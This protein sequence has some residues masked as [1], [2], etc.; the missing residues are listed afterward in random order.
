M[1]KFQVSAGGAA[2]CGIYCDKGM[3]KAA[4]QLSLYL[5]QITGAEF[6]Q[7]EERKGKRFEILQDETAK[8]FTYEIVEDV[9]VIK[10]PTHIKAGWGVFHML[11]SLAD[12]VF[13][14]STYEQIP[15]D[16]DLTLETDFYEHKPAFEFSKTSY[17]DH[18]DPLYAMK[19]G[20]DYMGYSE[21]DRDRLWG[22][23]A[24]HTIGRLVGY[25]KFKEHPE[26]FCMRDGKRLEPE[27]WMTIGGGMEIGNMQPC[28]SN[29][30]VFEI[31]CENLKKQMDAKPEAL[32]WSVSQDDNFNYC[33]CPECAKVDEE[34]GSHLGTYL[35]FVNKVAERFPD[36]IIST[37]AYQFT[38][39]PCKITK[40]AKNVN[41]V[42]CN[43]EAYRNKPI[44]TDPLN[45]DAKNELI[46]WRE[47]ADD[48]FYWDYCIQFTHLVSPF[49]NFRTLAENMKFFAEGGIRIMFSQTNR[50]WLGE[51]AELRGYY[52][53]KL[54]ENPWQDPQKIIE[55]FC[56]AYYGEASEYILEYIQIMHDALDA[57]PRMQMSIFGSPCDAV[58]SYLR[59]ELFEKYMNL[60]DEA[61]KAVA[62]DAELLNHVRVA[63]MPLYYAGVEIGYGDKYDQF[64]MLANFSKIAKENNVDMVWEVGRET[65]NQ[66]IANSMARLGSW[67]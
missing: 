7:L 42:L 29:P 21:E 35:R 5:T 11:D 47:I 55:R 39:K 32:Y 64:E 46:A 26:Y 45:V 48:I 37:L 2:L 3:E 31:V 22:N 44:V 53:A 1:S 36:K 33:Q 30:D 4:E 14:T 50:E 28:L 9:F 59:R 18:L 8:F 34:E 58:S 15:N 10:A 27:E 65:T 20:S 66:F 60:F 23:G 43:I 38:R 67:E 16:P 24:C 63:R 62:N 61:E 57:A 51:F 52:L 41:I 13:C 56:D 6:V 25:E 40:P 49:P 19:L 17:K 54:M 12:C